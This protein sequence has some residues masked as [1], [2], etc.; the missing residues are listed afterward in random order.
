MEIAIVGLGNVGKSLA[1]AFAR[2]GYRVYVGV[3]DED[4]AQMAAHE[5]YHENAT[6]HPMEEV[7]QHASIIFFCVTPTVIAE[8]CRRVGHLDGK[9]VIDTMNSIQTHPEGYANTFDA[10]SAIYPQCHVVKAF[11]T[12]G[13]ENILH[14]NFG[15]VPI[16]TFMA[17]DSK[18]AKEQVC[19][20]AKDLGFSN[21]YDFGGVEM[22]T[23]LED[24]AKA[25]L[26]LALL[27]GYGRTIAF[28]I[29]QRCPAS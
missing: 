11:S 5:N 9:I 28:K 16:D 26:N 29:L 3:K 1:R 18:H 17:G 12:T 4:E 6:I 20:M 14:P 27:Q 8:V 25:W 21:C 7:A 13:F 15:G 22:V 24:L 19:R 23:L 2:V 10:L